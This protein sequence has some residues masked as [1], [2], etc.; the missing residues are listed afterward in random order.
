M[1]K[2]WWWRQW[3]HLSPSTC[4]IKFGLFDITFVHLHTCGL[5]SYMLAV[6]FFLGGGGGA[7]GVDL[8]CASRSIG[9]ALYL[10]QPLRKIH[11]QNH[12]L[13]FL[14]E[15]VLCHQAIW[16]FDLTAEVLQ[17]CQRNWQP[18]HLTSPSE[19]TAVC[20]RQLGLPFH[21]FQPALK[22]L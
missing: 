22:H 8:T 2:A 21:W 6:F 13:V 4:K 9:F 17:L 20:K 15:S 7:G 14:G 12:M 19:M 1:I 10:L 11:C 3:L 5:V 18:L 16:L